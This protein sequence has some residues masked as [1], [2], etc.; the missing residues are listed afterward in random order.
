VAK[1]NKIEPKAQTGVC[2][3]NLSHDTSKISLIADCKSCMGRAD[4][5]DPKCLSG[6]LNGLHQ[7]YNVDSV[8]LSHYIETKYTHDSMQVLG[9]MVEI[10]QDLDQLAIRDPFGEIFEHNETISPQIKNQRKVSCEKCSLKPNNIFGKL[11]ESFI[12]DMFIFYEDLKDISSQIQ[13]NRNEDCIECINGT[14]S[15]FLYLFNKLE[16]LRSFVIY[17]GFRIVI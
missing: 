3:Y 10:L 2:K 8:I 14:Q 12:R 9:M 1:D 6:V 7:E 15:D 17:K 4:L 5:K 11:R 16:K 13:R